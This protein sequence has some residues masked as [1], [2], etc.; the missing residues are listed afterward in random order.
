MSVIYKDGQ[1][2][3]GNNSIE[4][5]V[6]VEVMPTADISLVGEVLMYVGETDS[7]YTNC[8]WYKCVSDT[9][10]T[11][12]TYSWVNVEVQNGTVSMELTQ[13]EYDNLPDEQ[14]S[15]GTVYYITD[16]I[17]FNPNSAVCGFTPVGTIISVMGNSA[18]RNYLACNGQV[19]D[20]LDYPE[21]A[22]YFEEQF[23]QVNKFG[24][25]GTTTFGIPDLRG[26]FLRGTGTNGHNTQGNG[27]SVGTHQ[28]ATEHVFSI[29][30]NQTRINFYGTEPQYPLNIDGTA[31]AGVTK[32]GMNVAATAYTAQA[33]TSTMYKSRPTNTSVLYCIAVRNIYVDARY[34]YSTDEKVVGTWIDGKPIYQK[35]INF[36]T[37]PNNTFKNVAHGISNFGKLIS[38]Y[39]TLDSG[40]LQ[41]V[42][43]FSYPDGITYNVG[44]YVTSTE[45]FIKTGTDRTSDT[46]FVTIQYTK[47]TD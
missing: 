28:D 9:S 40:S 4:E 21:L 45:L 34:D 27:S 19:V 14:K 23:G 16:S 35:T 6:K 25:N 13:Q 33:D 17:P 8:Y 30:T 24:G 2:Y 47:T 5:P 38:L 36:G 10:T 15:D 29:K 3:G 43:M 42:I 32:N 44:A 7:N 20:I 18:P 31:S 41:S 46:A 26:E 12:A 22:H 37:L 39:G 11:P 1:F